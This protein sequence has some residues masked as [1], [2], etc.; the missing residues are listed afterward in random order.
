MS[1]PEDPS[2]QNSAHKDAAAKREP[3]A[4]IDQPA[5][6]GTQ[7]FIQAHTAAANRNRLRRSELLLALGAFLA[8]VLVSW[9][10]LRFFG[11]NSYL[12]LAV[13][14]LNLI[15]LLVILFLVI[16]NGVKLFLARKRKVKG[17]GL[18]SKLV[19]AFMS[20]SLIPTILMF[21]VAV[22]FVQTSVDYWFRG[23]I[24]SS[25][26]QSLE[27]AQ[28]FYELTQKD[29]EAQG[30]Y[31]VEAIRDKELLWGAKGMERFL[32]DKAEEYGLSLVG[33]ISPGL[34]EQNWY[35]EREWEQ[36]WPEIKQ[37]VDWV[38]LKDKPR[39]WSTLH[40]GSQQD[41]VT[42]LIPVDDAKTGF[43]VLG[44]SIGQGLLEKMDQIVQG[45]REY[46]TIKTLKQPLKI[47][48]YLILGSMTLLIIFGAMWFGF[49][50]A[51]EISA[52]IQA[53]SLG[54]Q[55]IAHGDLGVRLNDNAGDELGVLVQ[56]FNIMAED[57][58]KSQ[59]GL[60]KA[61]K[62]LANQNL[63]LEQRREYMEAVL[64]TI[65][66]GVISLDQDGRISTVN[67]AAEDI[68]NTKSVL[69]I[70]QDPLSLLPES[71]GDLLR[72]AMERLKEAP[73]THWQRQLDLRLGEDEKKILVN[74]IG[75]RG[76]QGE[77]IGMLIVFEDIT[78]LD[79]MQRMAAWREVA[80]RIAHEI[81][82]P[83]TPIKLS[84]QRLER[85][86]GKDV[87][88]SSFVECTTLIVRQVEHLQQMV[89]EFSKFARLPE[90][91]P[92]RNRLQPLMEEVVTLF[93]NSHA[94]INWQL[95]IRNQVP[96]LKF[97]R[98]A[99]KQV[100]MNILTNASEVLGG[101][102]DPEVRIDID[103]D[104][105]AGWVRIQVADN[106]PGLDEEE[107]HRLFEPYFSKKRGNTGLGLTIVK[108]IVSDHQ[109]YVRVRKNEPSG[110]VFSIELPV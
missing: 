89:Q 62:D 55:R 35:A 21:L 15:L 101:G 48:F 20:L 58:E 72:S 61:N 100:F 97:D 6:S 40:K 7:N 18:R 67:K 64:N 31:I 16:R 68:L 53:L 109:G 83:L 73:E 43:L 95:E 3:S 49:R 51:K 60:N 41:L 52:P 5:Q 44:N 57:L 87:R 28:S 23:K 91:T 96:P 33:V 19:L 32:Q 22:K 79:K 2:V 50:L 36:A 102:A 81:K 108:S 59:H 24:D 82:N 54:T 103:F 78:E 84:A 75:L 38:G 76:G 85:K 70:N 77:E 42:G 27:I 26:E 47:A 104:R 17:S 10:E 66:S 80:K 88:D 12:F 1:T 92:E 37:S 9:I 105:K 99:M 69:L 74:A 107:M 86:F 11:V 56:S 106:G 63:E 71:Y 39:Y 45:V 93:Q 14:N 4:L 13:F 98:S 29:L 8:I 34:K 94:H 110:S 65:T 90:V 25:L 30:R 46:K